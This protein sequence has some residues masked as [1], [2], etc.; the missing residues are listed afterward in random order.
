MENELVLEKALRRHFHFD[1]FRPGQKEVIEGVLGGGD[2][3]AV[4]PTGSGKSLCYQLP[5]LL[6]PGLTLVISPLVALMKDQVDNLHERK[7]FQATLLNSQIGVE[8]YRLRMQGIRGG[9]YKLIYVAPERLRN[10]NFF[11]LVSDLGLDLLVVDEAHCLSQWGHDFR[12]DYLWIA[13]FYKRL[14]K[15]PRIMALTATATPQVQQDIITQLDIP[16][17]GRV[18]TGS[19]RPNLYI[20]AR[21]TAGEREK[22]AAL[23]EFLRGRRGSGII[24]AATRK[25]SEQVAAWVRD[26]LGLASACYHAGLSSAERTRVQEAFIREEAEVVVATNAFGMGIDKANIRY[27]AHYSLPSSLEAYY[28][29]IGRAGRDGLPAHCLLLFSLKDVRLQEWI[30]SNDAV[31]RADLA[32][33]WRICARHS[34]RAGCRAP[35][36]DG[37]GG[38]V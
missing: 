27:V 31:K 23:Q 36:R 8:E 11:E 12:P 18:A 38:P 2:V 16:G 29:E 5:A 7:L 22:Q 34:D 19:D 10:K 26:Y 15:R 9:G 20:T 1:R 37:A 3:L 25:E 33:F 24:Y 13:D 6:L 30:I 14:P 21:R 17:A 35:G 32:A 4:M 28:Q